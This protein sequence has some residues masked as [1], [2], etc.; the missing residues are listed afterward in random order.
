VSSYKTFIALLRGIN[1]GGNNI[2][3]M[4]ELVAVLEGLGLSQVKTYIQSGNVV[5]QSES[6]NRQ[7][8]SQAISAAIGGSYGFAPHVLVLDLPAFQE[9]VAANPFP[10]AGHEPKTLHLF[11]LDEIP[12]SPDLAVL[13]RLKA[14]NERYRLINNVFYLHAPDGMGR[15]KLA[16]KVEKVL[17]VATT[18]RNWRTV[19]KLMSMALEVASIAPQDSQMETL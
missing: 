12:P 2:L 14:E 19:S 10:E 7:E 6:N 13:E 8:L 11:F 3:P 5:F 9:A 16:E 4:R 1:V 15:S 17:G 18:A